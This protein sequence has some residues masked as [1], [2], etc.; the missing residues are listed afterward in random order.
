MIKGIIFDLDGTLLNTAQDITTA[1]NKTMDKYNLNTFSV[2]EVI[3]KVGNG[4]LKLVDRCLPEDKK[5]LLE[6]AFKEFCNNYEKCYLDE[7]KVYEGINEL[8]LELNKREILVG[9]NTNKQN[10]FCEKLLSSRFPDVK[11]YRIIG[12][13]DGIPGK[14][15]PYSSLEIVKDMNFDN[16]EV[17]YV[18]DSDTDILTAKNANLKAIGC[19]WGFRDKDT[20]IKAGADY[21]ISKP[22]EILNY[23]D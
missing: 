23:L 2:E 5:E 6:E 11:F 10:E 22:E 20:L 12:N 4:M 9:V 14:P 8:L 3:Q 1:V 16:E 21:I 18:G 7:T 17:L 13:R 19:L 15:D